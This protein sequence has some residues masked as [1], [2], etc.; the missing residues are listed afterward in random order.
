MRLVP[1]LSDSFFRISFSV[2]REDSHQVGIPKT[3]CG[4]IFTYAGVLLIMSCLFNHFV[5]LFFREY[6]IPDLLAMRVAETICLRPRL[7][8]TS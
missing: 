4:L 5:Q 8:F 2:D 7:F 1:F 3:I 6:A